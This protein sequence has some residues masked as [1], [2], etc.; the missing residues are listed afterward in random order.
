MNIYERLILRKGSE[1][2][3]KRFKIINDEMRILRRFVEK[4]SPERNTKDMS[5]EELFKV[6]GKIA[7]SH[8]KVV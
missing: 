3:V 4:F 8:K 7:R 2:M 6:V 5:Y 1:L